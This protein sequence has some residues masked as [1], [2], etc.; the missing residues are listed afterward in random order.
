MSTSIRY[1]FPSGFGAITA[2]NQTA[3]ALGSA[4]QDLIKKAVSDP[5]F[6]AIL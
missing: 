6:A 5:R 3:Q 2:C 4:V 1:D